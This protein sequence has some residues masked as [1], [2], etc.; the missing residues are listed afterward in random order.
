M[1]RSAAA[2]RFDV[3]PAGHFQH[4]DAQ[5]G[6]GEQRERGLADAGGRCGDEH[7]VHPTVLQLSPSGSPP[8]VAPWPAPARRSPPIAAGSW[9]PRT[10]RRRTSASASGR[11]R[12]CRSGACCALTAYAMPYAPC[13]SSPSS[14]SIDAVDRRSERVA[15][16]VQRH[17]EHVAEHPLAQQRRQRLAV[18]RGEVGVQLGRRGRD[19]GRGCRPATAA[20]PRRSTG[21][22]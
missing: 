11:C 19:V 10:A 20:P 6:G 5:L 7:M 3:H 14:S 22:S 21:H 16:V 18:Q 17:R 13:I 2:E 4:A 1:L 9:C 12:P 8:A 15:R